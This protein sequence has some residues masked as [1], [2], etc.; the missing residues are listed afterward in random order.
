MRAQ[1]NLAD[2]DVRVADLEQEFLH[3][4][5]RWGESIEAKDRYTQGHCERVAE[6]GCAIAQ[7]SGLDS[8][9]MFWFRIG[10]LLHDVGKLAIPEEVLNKPG[11]LDADEWALIRSHPTAGVDGGH[12]P[13]PP[14]PSPTRRWRP[15]RG[16]S[17]PTSASWT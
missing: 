11:K 16:A 5:R 13:T 7:R 17:R 10:A 4:A 12:A 9:A 8:H 3:V 15:S 1:P 14:S 2:V 6:L